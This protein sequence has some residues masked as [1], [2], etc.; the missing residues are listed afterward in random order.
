MP[1]PRHIGII[2]YGAIGRQL[3][4]RLLSDPTYRVTVL[5]RRTGD[6]LATTGLSFTTSLPEL[7]SNCPDLVVEAASAQA[8][9]TVIPRCLEV[10]ID[11]IAASVG[12]L[13][14]PEILGLI[15][16]IC[17]TSGARLVLP[18]GAV[19]GLDYLAAAA[20]AGDASVVYTSRKP[21]AAWR[22]ELVA[23]GRDGDD[24]PVILFEGS[25]PDAAVLYP[26]NLNAGL[27]VAL[28]AGIERTHVRV[29][30]DPTVRENIH[31]IEVTSAAGRAHFRF[32]NAP[33]PHN[34][35]TSAITAFSLAAT[36]MRHFGPFQ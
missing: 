23:L 32:E 28:A 13:N 18:S 15:A 6:E 22:A 31:E 14:T 2:G 26:K 25:A 3:A 11:V 21:P 30:A 16:D 17:A 29:I 1:E 9:L 33:S 7:L 12:A 10:G 4:A 35:K 24:G 19:G 34:P 27:T 8:F 20:L 36:V 5:M